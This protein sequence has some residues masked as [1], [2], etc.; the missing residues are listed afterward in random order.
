MT[1]TP[2][3]ACIGIIGKHV[4]TTKADEPLHISLFPPHEEQE[5][6]MSFILN[7]SL[8]I[9][10]I[11]TRAKTVDQDLGLLH[12]VDERLA[13]YGWLTNTGIKFIIIVDMMGRLAKEE[14]D[15]KRKAQPIVG[16]RD[17]EM[18]PAFRAVQTAYIQLMLNPFFTPE[19]RTPLQ[20]AN[21]NGRPATITSKKFATELQRIGHAWSPGVTSI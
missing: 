20:L 2:S 1:A 13:A 14:P 18:K 3:I 5:L 11:R 17:A 6:D 8:D 19:E 9:F 10:D 12:A 16:L 4:R 15:D 7:S 21:S